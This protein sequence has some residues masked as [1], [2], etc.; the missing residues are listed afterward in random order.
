MVILTIITDSNNHTV[1]FKESLKNVQYM[2]LLSC[3]LNN[4]WK[5]LKTDGKI[6]IYDKDGVPIVQKIGPQCILVWDFTPIW[7]GLNK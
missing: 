4:S 1:Y 2:R 3:S 7:C 6:Y 5:N